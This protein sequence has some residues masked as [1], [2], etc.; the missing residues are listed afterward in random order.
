MVLGD[1]Q[2]MVRGRDLQQHDAHQRTVE[3]VERA[4][5]LLRDRLLDG[6]VL[7]LLALDH[8]RQVGLDD[9]PGVLSLF[10]E[11]GTQRFMTLHQGLERVLQCRDIQLTAQV[12]CGRYVVGGAA[13]IQLPKEPLAFLGEGQCQ[14]PVAPQ[15]HHRA[16]SAGLQPCAGRRERFQRRLLEQRS[17]RHVQL[18]VVTHAG[19]H[20]SG[21]QRMAT[22]FEEMVI[23][24]H[25]LD[26]QHRLPDRRQLHV[27]RALRSAVGVSRLAQVRQRQ[28][29]AVKLAVVVQRQ[30]IEH[31]PMPRHHVI[32]QGLA[33]DRRQRL[34]IQ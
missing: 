12:Q 9:L 19:D 23:E 33:Q 8:H 22:A 6:R 18:E 29:A 21:Q 15:R 4:L 7:H 11:G 28:C 17:Q 16:G 2:H 14:R 34:G 1:H 30:G 3:Q 25:L 24:P 20:L 13:G 32:R 27:Q 31:Q 10:H 26:V 5:D